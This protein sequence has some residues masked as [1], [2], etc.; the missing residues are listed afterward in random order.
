MGETVHLTAIDG[1]TISA[2]RAEPSGT[3]KGALVVLQEIFG[4]NG[5]MRSVC[6]GFA[7]AGYMA[8]APALYDRVEPGIEL[9]YDGPDVETGRTVRAQT[10][11]ADVLKDVQAAIDAAADA[12]PVGV[13]GY[14]WGGSLA[15]LSA[16][17]LTGLAA[18]V[19]Y[20]GGQ[21]VP[22][23]T[24]MPKVPIILHFG[25]KDHGIPMSDVET[26]RQRHPDTSIFVYPA[27]HGFNCDERGGYDKPSAE[28][29]LDRTLKFF[30]EKLR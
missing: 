28:L 17:R 11:L 25:E 2:Y 12:G 18:A 26:I 20:Y 7:R 15:F 13:I 27:G 19:G 30:A 9:G 4:V 3:P 6:D 8:L 21:I 16:T 29:A 14:C 24:E 10:D 23:V 1:K 22:F 5:H